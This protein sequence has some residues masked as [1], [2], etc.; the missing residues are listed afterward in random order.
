MIR[1]NYVVVVIYLLLAVVPLI[2]A[3]FL[4]DY[5]YLPKIIAIYCFAIILYVCHAIATKKS[6]ITNDALSI[7]LLLYW[8][9]LV[10]STIFSINYTNTIWGGFRREEGLFAILAYGVLFVISKT[11]YTHCQKY[12]KWI[13]L[14]AVLVSLYGIMQYF[15]F[16]PIPRD[17]IRYSWVSTFSTMGNPNFL[18]SYLVLLFPISAFEYLKS[19]KVHYLPTCAMIYLCLL[20]TFT[21]SAYLGFGVTF[22]MLVFYILKNRAYRKKFILLLTILLLITVSVNIQSEGRLLRRFLSIGGDAQKFIAK[23][24]NYEKAGASRIY[25]WSRTLVLIKERPLVGYGLENL[26]IV[27]T[28]KYK[29]EMMEKYGKVYL[30]DKAHNEYLHIAVTTG[31]PSL[32]LYLTFIGI[33]M[34]KGIKHTKSDSD[35]MMYLTAVTSYLV[36]AFFNISVVCVAFIFWI[37]LGAIV[38][39]HA[40]EKDISHQLTTNKDCYII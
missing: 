26:G 7:I 5:F 37:F 18:G 30:Y 10:V 32:I 31:I 23:E 22:I 27:F 25:I 35:Y 12:I 39:P 21:R 9:T 16:D 14:S 33:C 40:F 3:P 6:E 19:Q 36:Q 38:N 20:L 11:Y 15:G 28:A 34:A 24:E 2:I 4:Y 8:L 13:I 17:D 1:R 29:D